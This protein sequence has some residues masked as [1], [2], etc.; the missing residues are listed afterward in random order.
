MVRAGTTSNMLGTLQLNR[1]LLE[2]Q[3]LLRRVAVS[4]SEAIE[5]LVGM[6]AQVPVSPYVGLWS[7]L[8]K[9]RPEELEHLLV[10]REAV[11]AP[12]M[13]STLHLV[14]GR[15]FASIW[16]LAQAVLERT[17]KST[18]FGR[19]L[20]GLQPDAIAVVAKPYLDQQPRTLAELGRFLSAHW[21]DRK[22]ESLAYAIRFSL[23]LV[24]VPPRG[25]WRKS[26]QAK[27][28][29]AGTWLA[30]S[31]SRRKGSLRSLFLRYL[32]AFGPASVTDFQT[33][34]GI[35]GGR[36]AIERLRPQLRIFRDES[37]RELL[38]VADGILPEPKMPAPA[39]FLPEYENVLLGHADRSRIIPD[40]IRAKIGIGQPTVLI[41]GFVGATWKINRER[42]SK[43]LTISVLTETTRRQLE[44]L[45]KQGT[46]LLEFLGETRGKVEIRPAG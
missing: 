20:N 41:N 44:E 40:E 10:N 22:P 7:R 19:D 9:F 34:S 31:I 45:T 28:A 6:Q 4:A 11:R 21:P 16:P 36:E 42:K 29:V 23:P 46:S 8:S 18:E 3:F 14:S 32:A 37:D 25:L 15:D 2:R 26:G 43:V 24:Q 13:R 1:A 35:A 12:L 30:R 39:R 38:D 27:W 17:F 33:W 5:H